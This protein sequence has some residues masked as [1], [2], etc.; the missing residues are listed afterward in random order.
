MRP[1]EGTFLFFLADESVLFHEPAQKLFCLNTTA[2]FIW[3]ML[4]EGKNRQVMAAELQATFSLTKVEAAGYLEQTETLLKTFGVLKGFEKTLKSEAKITAEDPPIVAYDNMIFV[5]ER[6]YRLLSSRICMRYSH[7]DQLALIDPVLG[8]LHDEK[9]SEPTVTFDIINGQDGRILLCRD[10]LP[11]LSCDE[12]IRLAPL[13]KSLVW[14]TAIHAHDFFLNIHA[15]VVSDGKQCYLFPAAPGSGKSTLTAALVHHGFEYFSD[16][17]A[18]LHAEGLLVEPVPLALCV[19][20]TGMEVLSRYY[21]QLRELSVHLRS[22]GK[23]VRYLPPPAQFVP[24]AKTRRTVAAIIFPR[25][26]P[27]QATT[28]VPIGSME[29]LRLLMHQCLIVDTRLDMDKVA[30]LLTWIEKIPC[31]CLTVSDL[32]EAVALLQELTRD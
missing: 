20:N 15:G 17:V 8:H 12:Y 1:A 22:D 6:H 16:E 30:G 19:K 32:D 31:Y 27:E 3:C 29:A 24:P 11:V 2:T 5:A 10:Q 26:L 7:G 23:R 28:L 9:P 25:Y 14:Q 18:L 13:A 4:E 21:P